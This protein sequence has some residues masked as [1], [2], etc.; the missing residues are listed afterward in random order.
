MLS[1]MVILTDI[2]IENTVNIYIIGH[3][4]SFLFS[5]KFVCLFVNKTILANYINDIKVFK[6]W[7]FL[8]LII[9]L[10]GMDIVNQ[11]KLHSRKQRTV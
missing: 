8:S 6:D 11:C 2:I 1:V 7:F 4:A 10:I 5:V 3:V 9:D